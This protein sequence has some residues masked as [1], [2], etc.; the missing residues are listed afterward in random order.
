[1]AIINS[2]RTIQNTLYLD[3]IRQAIGL[4]YGDNNITTHSCYQVMFYGL[5]IRF[6]DSRYSLQSL[7]QMGISSALIPN[8][9][10]LCMK[11][12]SPCSGFVK[13]SAIICF[14]GQYITVNSLSLILSVTK[15]YLILICLDPL[16]HDCMPLFSN[17]IALW[18]SWQTY[19]SSTAYP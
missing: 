6:K 19:T 11:Q 7:M 2:S 10:F 13:K 5:I 18:L 16:P 4:S 1:M 14:V 3:Q 12:S 8:T 15:K 9:E 17:R